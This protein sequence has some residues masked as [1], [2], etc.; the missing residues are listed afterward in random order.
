M[1]LDATDTALVDP[2]AGRVQVRG[3]QVLRENPWK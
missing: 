3:A 2:K 1:S